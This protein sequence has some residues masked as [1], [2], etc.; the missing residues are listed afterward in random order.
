MLFDTAKVVQLRHKP[1]ERRLMIKEIFQQAKAQG[2]ISFQGKKREN[3]PLLGPLA[4]DEQTSAAF[5]SKLSLTLCPITPTR[6]P[7]APSSTR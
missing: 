6:S 3:A 4:A 5:G 7:Q 2:A 1:E